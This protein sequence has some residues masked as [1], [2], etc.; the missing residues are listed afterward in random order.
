MF[1]FMQ[2]LFMMLG[3][4][5]YLW[6]V[7]KQK[8]RDEWVDL[9]LVYGTWCSRTGVSIPRAFDPMFEVFNRQYCGLKF[10]GVQVFVYNEN[11]DV[12]IGERTTGCWLLDVGAAGL[13]KTGESL[14]ECALHELD[15]ELGIC[16]VRYGMVFVGMMYPCQDLTCVV[17]V[18]HVVVPNG[19]ILQSTDGTYSRTFTVPAGGVRN[20]LRNYPVSDLPVT[21]RDTYALLSLL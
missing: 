10:S 5:V 16:G 6:V 12:Y 3:Y 14:R 8:R 19:T 13:C 17:A 18:Y 11:G 7:A 20:F 21:K 1:F 9:M 15:E 4:M 2:V